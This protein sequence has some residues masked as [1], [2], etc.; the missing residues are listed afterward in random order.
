MPLEWE[1]PIYAPQQYLL[2]SIGKVTN[3][4]KGMSEGLAHLRAHST[5]DRFRID[6]DRMEQDDREASIAHWRLQ[7]ALAGEKGWEVAQF[8][9]PM[10]RRVIAIIGPAPR[11]PKI[12]QAFK[13]GNPWALGMKAPTFNAVTGRSEVEEDEELAR[14]LLLN[15]EDILTPEQ[16][17][18]EAE[19]QRRERLEVHADTDLMQELR[20]MLAEAKAHA[21]ELK[22]ELARRAAAPPKNK[23]G[24]PKKAPAEVTP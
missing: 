21:A 18:R 5:T 17:L 6:Y 12:A 10:D 3:L 9:Q 15:R 2:H 19:A 14:V 22:A 13:A 8:G 20:E 24:R 7:V 16:A 11:S 4:P 23:G 1:A